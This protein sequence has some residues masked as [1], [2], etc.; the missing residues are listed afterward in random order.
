MTPNRDNVGNCLHGIKG[1]FFMGAPAVIST[2]R[3][4]FTGGVDESN[5]KKIFVI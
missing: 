1:A 3:L 5:R 4:N 2:H